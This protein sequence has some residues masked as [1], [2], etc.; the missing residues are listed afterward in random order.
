MD[1][2]SAHGL[3][4]VATNYQRSS[5]LQTTLDDTYIPNLKMNF[6]FDIT[7][8]GFDINNNGEIEPGKE[9][10]LKVRPLGND[11]NNNGQFEPNELEHRIL[12]VEG[13]GN[14]FGNISTDEMAN[15]AN[16]ATEIVKNHDVH[17]INRSIGMTCGK[18]HQFFWQRFSLAP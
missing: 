15:M 18:K 7:T 1:T 4:T 10:E 8:Q 12:I 11:F 9:S 6:D 16:T 17:S 14:G 13:Q 2:S 5:H 3:I